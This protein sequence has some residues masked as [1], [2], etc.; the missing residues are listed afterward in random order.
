MVRIEFPA[1]R[2]FR[3]SNNSPKHFSIMSSDTIMDHL[4]HVP[5]NH[6][7]ITWLTLRRP[8][9]FPSQK[10]NSRDVGIIITTSA[11]Q[12]RCAFQISH[13]L[14]TSL[15]NRLFSSSCLSIQI[16]FMLPTLS[17]LQING[18]EVLLNS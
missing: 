4:H 11:I 12:K 6:R 17:Y 9:Q 18:S 14:S 15:Y 10:Y 1:K 5:P 3:N 13:H 8:R 2:T 16:N 7:I